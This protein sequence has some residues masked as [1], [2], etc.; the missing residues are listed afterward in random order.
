MSDVENLGMG[1]VGM[2]TEIYLLNSNSREH[3]TS[4]TSP[5]QRRYGQLHPCPANLNG[6][7]MNSTVTA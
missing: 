5:L 3:I 1:N 2:G 4:D 6:A 7:R